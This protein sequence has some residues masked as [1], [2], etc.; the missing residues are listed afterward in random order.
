MHDGTPRQTVSQEW[1]KCVHPGCDESY[2]GETKQALK[3]RLNQHLKPS[4]SGI[5]TNDSPVY[6]HTETSG[7]NTLATD[8][9]ILD[10]EARWFERGVKEAIWERVEAPP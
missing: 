8:V 4:S 5:S 2:V 9:K 3:Q 7:H 6:T 10:E 1:D